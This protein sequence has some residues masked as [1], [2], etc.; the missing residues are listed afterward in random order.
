MNPTT[1]EPVRAS[2]WPPDSDTAFWASRTT[3]DD[4]R[5]AE[6]SWMALADMLDRFPT[7]A[8]FYLWENGVYP[9]DA[10]MPPELDADDDTPLDDGAY[11]EPTA[12]DLAWLESQRA[13]SMDLPLTRAALERRIA[14]LREAMGA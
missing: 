8:E 2:Q 6:A 4:L 7:E 10:C 14:G 3:Y 9:P 13:D 5:E 1:P 12:D 11:F